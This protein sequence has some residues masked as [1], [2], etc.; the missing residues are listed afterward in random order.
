MPGI[1]PFV[2][3]HVIGALIVGAV[4]G[5]FLDVK[6]V[7]TFSGLL[8]A[9]AAISSLVCWWRPG[10]D[11]AGWKLWLTATFANPMMLA[12]IAFTIDQYD[13]LM[14]GPADGCMLASVGPMTVEACLPSPLIKFG[15]PLVE[16][17]EV[18]H[19]ASLHRRP[20]RRRIG[21]LRAGSC[22]GR[23]GSQPCAALL[24][25]RAISCLICPWRPLDAPWR[26][27]LL[28]GTLTNLAMLMS[29]GELAVQ[30]LCLFG[31][32]SNCFGLALAA[33]LFDDRHL[34]GPGRLRADVAL[35][36]GPKSRLGRD[37]PGE[38]H[39]K[40]RATP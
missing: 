32:G 13:C 1:H 23:H 16:A 37:R 2:W 21:S 40:R 36:E 9:N 18:G 25:R 20:G 35:V 22:L 15:R 19:A 28:I 39:W 33:A 12:A 24:C 3:G 11:A 14:G 17:Q 29:L 34:P 8:A 38:A 26:K 7:F 6:A 27:L 5:S 4:S 30:L 10:L 31:R